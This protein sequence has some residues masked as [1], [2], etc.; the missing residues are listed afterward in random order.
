M[1]NIEFKAAC[2]NAAQFF[3]LLRLAQDAG[4]QQSH[5]MLQSDTYFHAEHGRLKLRTITEQNS[6]KHELI[7]YQRADSTESRLSNYFYYTVPDAG[8]LKQALAAALSIDVVVEKHR[9]VYMYHTTRVHFDDVAQ[10]GYFV[11]LETVLQN[12]T[13]QDEEQLG[14]NEHFEVIRLLG[15]AALQPIS[16]SYRELMLQTQN[17]YKNP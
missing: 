4:L 5:D 14:Q 8:D 2:T 10:L 7:G 11:E 12:D 17:N 9:I 15:L 13:T 3:A 1:R 16:G 6:V